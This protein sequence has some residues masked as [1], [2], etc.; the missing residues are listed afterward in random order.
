MLIRSRT[1]QILGLT[2]A[3]AV[4]PTA[5]AQV[6]TPGLSDFYRAPTTPLETWEVVSYLIRIGQ[7]GQAVPYIKKFIADNPDD[8]ALLD[9]R[10]EYGV[11]SILRLSDY[12]ETRP[13][14]QV[15][16]KRV[17]EAS[18]RA[19]TEPARMERAIAGLSK[20]K[21]EQ[22]V[23]V[24][25]LREAG[26]YAIPPWV[27]ALS[28]GGLD[29]SVRSSLAENLG[30][31]DRNAVPALIAAL[32]SPDA[33]LVGD[34]ARALGKIGDTR[35]IPA[36]T[37][38]AA[39]RDPES[40]AKGQAAVAIFQLT[41]RDFAS[42][43]RTPV[44]VL[45]DEARNYH[46]HAYR[47]P[48]DPVVIWLWDESAKVPAPVQVPVRDA[49]GVLGLRAALEAIQLDPTDVEAK[50]N[51]L[52][53]GLDREPAAWKAA[54]LEAGP[55]VLGKVL[56]RA[57]NEKRTDLAATITP[58]LGQL[59]NRNDLLITD[60][61]NA[62]V[63]ALISAD[64]R[65]QFAGAEALVK[66]D[67]RKPFPGS[68]RLV[69][70]LARF[71]SGQSNPR[72]LVIDGNAE[73]ASQV[74]GYLRGLGY[75]ARSIPTAAQGFTEAADSA[76]IELIAIDPNTVSDPWDLADLL[77]NLKADPRT[78]GIPIFIVGPLAVL[79]QISPKLESFPDT[80]FLVTPAETQ[81]LKDQVDRGLK[82]L[83]VRTFSSEERTAYA[84]RAATLLAQIARSPGSPF[85]ADLPLAEPMLSL[86]LNGP[87]AA[88]E[89][90]EA[91]GDIPG[92][93]AQR[94]LAD[95][96]LDP[97]KPAP[98]RLST[99]VQLARNIRRFGPKLASEQERRLVEELGQEADPT[100]KDALA[101]VVGALKPGPDASASASASLI[102]TYRPSSP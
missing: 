26:P 9:V 100:L 90:A 3:L 96:A 97:S 25:R 81:L 94:S 1:A 65:T 60:K 18:I 91:L 22:A 45:S 41:G 57:I 28:V 92:T 66:L 15:L 13:Y 19:A 98:V 99:A 20:S 63:D 54:A 70:V 2:L 35:A 48:G 69:P 87:V 31:L 102:P 4:G 93:D 10:D 55:A 7:P 89:A 37:Y 51:Q 5:L 34:V 95:V 43:P 72:A 17:A 44:R 38:L 53:L 82:S 16:A 14:A 75:D 86:A 88:I 83:G 80:R 101:A 11:G 21:E 77:G 59:A 23:A 30:R 56:R 27:R 73:R 67:P 85:E 74:T 49:E 42:Q 61:P 46:N 68:S 78:S 52:G 32:D 50:V 47:F 12:P 76:D 79:D 36:L 64:R 6:Q 84:K 8:A 71:L 29:A 33:A 39:R 40:L 58:I 24:E 62:L